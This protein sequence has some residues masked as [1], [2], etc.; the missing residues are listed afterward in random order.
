M[1]ELMF[2]IC[3][4]NTMCIAVQFLVAR[5]TPLERD[6]DAPRQSLCAPV[7]EV[8]KSVK[9]SP[10]LLYHLAAVQCFV[11]IGNTAW[12]IYG[13]QWFTASV[14]HGDQNAP[15]GSE[16]KIAYGEGN[17]AFSHGGQARSVLQLLSAIVIIAILLRNWLRPR[18]VYAPCIFIGGVASILAAFAVGHSGGFAMLCMTLSVMPETGSFAI[19]FGLVATLNK[20]A[21]EEGKQVSTALQMS[22]LNCCVTVG[23]QIC[24][25]TL[26]AIE[27]SLSLEK[28]LPCVFMLA[29]AAQAVAGSGA[30][31]LDD[32][33]PAQV[34]AEMDPETSRDTMDA[35]STAVEVNA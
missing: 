35:V 6:A 24:T 14:F 18:L 10:R 25:T 9:S 12:N 15:E 30:L 20:R 22:L 26:A 28:A 23:Q 3:L 13:G 29:A 21:E 1:L 16:A 19:P 34:E 2:G 33:P 7:I 8:V 11:W 4:L 5:E 17:A 31:C 32:A 27:G